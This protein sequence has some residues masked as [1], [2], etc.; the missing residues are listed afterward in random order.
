MPTPS[1]EQVVDDS[2]MLHASCPPDDDRSN[3]WRTTDS[4]SI[5]SNDITPTMINEQIMAPQSDPQGPPSSAETYIDDSQQSNKQVDA[6]EGTSSSEIMSPASVD[7]KPEGSDQQVSLTDS[8]AS[9][10]P[11]MSYEFSNVRVSEPI[12]IDIYSY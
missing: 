10:T 6:V 1:N 3:N 4:E 8:Y 12:A 7:D 5:P 9:G 2:R 11:S